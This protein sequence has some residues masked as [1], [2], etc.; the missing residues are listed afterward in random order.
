M[1]ANWDLHLY[2]G[3]SY[4]RAGPTTPSGQAVPAMPPR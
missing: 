3:L 1:T 4:L 2:A